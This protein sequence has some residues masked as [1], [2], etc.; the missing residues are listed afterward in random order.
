MSSI[1]QKGIIPDW[2]YDVYHPLTGKNH[3][4]G[5]ANIQNLVTGQCWVYWACRNIEGGEGHRHIPQ[6]ATISQEMQ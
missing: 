3:I 1:L 6:C 4:N 2:Q 5:P